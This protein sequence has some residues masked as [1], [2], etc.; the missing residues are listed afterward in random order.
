M[1][2]LQSHCSVRA[3]RFSSFVESHARFPG[4]ASNASE[5]SVRFYL[6]HMIRYEEITCRKK[7]IGKELKLPH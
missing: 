4:R 6:N 5:M 2:R 3:H 7:L 1:K